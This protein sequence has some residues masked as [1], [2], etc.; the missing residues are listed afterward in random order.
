MTGLCCLALVRADRGRPFSAGL[1][2]ALACAFKWTAWPAVAVTAALLGA[3]SGRR[4]AVRASVTAAAGAALLVLP[5][6]LRSPEAVFQQV[7]AFPAGRAELPSPARSP[8]PGRLLAELGP[9]GWHLASALLLLAGLAV[10][11]SL[12]LRPPRHA[13]A[14]ADRLALGLSLAFLLAPASRFGY[15]AL[16][17][18]LAVLARLRAPVSRPAPPVPEQD[19]PVGD[20]HRPCVPPTEPGTAEPPA[21]RSSATESPPPPPPP[22]APP[23]PAHAHRFEVVPAP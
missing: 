6:A 10:G 5:A 20:H 17:V 4:A 22:A 9:T 12:R 13:V 14:A 18:L 2:L 7:F 23:E 8:L 16:P 11:A 1:A 19:R 15:L 21:S 3:T